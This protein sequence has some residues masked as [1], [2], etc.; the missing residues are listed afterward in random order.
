MLFDLRGRGRRR[1]VRVL[2]IGLALL[3]GVGLVGFGVG[4]GF[5]G[6]GL[7]SAATNSEGSN[8]ASYQ[9]QIAKYRKLTKSNPR[10]VSAWENLTRSLLHEAGGEG[11]V[12]TSGLT[13][14][15]HKVFEETAKAWNTYLALES[16]KPSLELSKDM[17]RIFGEEGLNQASQEVTLLQVIVAA[18][19]TNVSYYADLAE[20][21][22]K[23]HDTSIGDLAAEK[24]VALSPS[25]GREH[26]K[27]ELSEFKKNIE[28]ESSSSS[29]STSLPSVSGSK[30]ISSPSG[31]ITSTGAST[32]TKA[33]AKK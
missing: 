33:K 18:E 12:T 22:Y 17:L 25:S 26:L 32:T 15:G 30:T 8:S 27:R 7:L 4:G 29:S 9:K 3:I 16:K 20:L 2:Y 28:K 14:Q 1:T 10:D 6:G 11:F 21:A 13:S 24:A 31:V 23:A 19:P 5:G